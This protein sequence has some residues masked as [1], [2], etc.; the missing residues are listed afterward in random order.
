VLLDNLLANPDGSDC[1]IYQTASGKSGGVYVTEVAVTLTVQR[2][3]WTRRR[4]CI[5][6]KRRRC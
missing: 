5:S 2:S 4:T 1:F 6:K 3:R